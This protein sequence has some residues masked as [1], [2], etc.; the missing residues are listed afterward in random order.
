MKSE[1]FQM[2]RV[3]LAVSCRDC[4]SLPK[5][6][7]AGECFGDRQQF[8]RMHNGVVVHRG[9]YH[10]EWM[11][12]IISQLRGHHEPQEEKV[13]A[14]V[15]A[16]IRPGASML[17]LGSY[18]AYYSMWF[19]QQVKSARSYCVEPVPEKLAVGE[20]HFRLNQMQGTFL[21]GFVG[22]ESD[23]R[24]TFIDWDGRQSDVPMISVDG[25]MKQY[26]LET[27]DLLH[28]DVQGAEY[29]M[30]LGAA[31]A[32]GSHRIGYV[33]ISTHGCEHERCVRY[34]EKCGYRIIAAHS[35]LESFSGDGLIVA[36]APEHPGPDRVDISVRNVSCAEQL[37]YQLARM[38]RSMSRW[39]SGNR[40]DLL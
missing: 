23:P 20:E 21:N 31:H 13:F 39:V 8:Q 22:R 1:H 27:I 7:G 4:D 3:K 35:V 29:D 17:E 9:S 2:E 24:G 33:F 11:T 25:L 16:H 28:A 37:R 36:R 34:L 40:M 6:I 38:H 30:L 19:Q 18:W 5:V 15:L 32:L 26:G 14:E 12:E 10:G